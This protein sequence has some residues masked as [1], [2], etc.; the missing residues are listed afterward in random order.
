MDAVSVLG[1]IACLIEFKARRV[2]TIHH[3]RK[4][5]SRRDHMKVIGLCPDHHFEWGEYPNAVHKS[6]RLFEETIGTEDDL[7]DMVANLLDK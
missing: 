6:K 4:Y 1:C 3:V 5:T 7:L 2:A